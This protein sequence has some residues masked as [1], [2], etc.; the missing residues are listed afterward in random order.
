M[1]QTARVVVIIV[2]YRSAELTLRSLAAL[3]GERDPSWLDLHVYVVENASGDAERL[4]AEIDARFAAFTTLIVSEH[5]AGFGAGNNC[6]LRHLAETKDPAEYCFFLNPDTEVRPGAVRALVDFLREHPQVGVVGSGIEHPDGSDWPIA[7][8]F[9]SVWS[10]IES[11]C[12]IA[13]ITRWLRE[14]TTAR[15][16]GQEPAPVDWLC[17]AAFMVRRSVIERVGGFDETFFLYF[18][19]IDLCLRAWR[20]G[21]ECWYVPHS[22]VMHIRGQS[23]GVTALGEPPRRLPRYWFESRRHF[24]VTH[25]GLAYAALADLAALGG[26]GIGLFKRML[27]RQPNT[28]HLLRDLL[29]SSV[30]LP[31]NRSQLPAPRRYVPTPHWE[32][33]HDGSAGSHRTK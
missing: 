28:P 9:P 24:Y 14:H 11:G 30:L 31:W 3:A 13:A 33:K 17:G 4:S 29:R 18:E 8:R 12:T 26:N 20:A 2:N 10:E 21:F 6:G 32:Q 19:E 22:R 1:A 15:T 7:F 23:T 5:N 16:M 25:R 27:R